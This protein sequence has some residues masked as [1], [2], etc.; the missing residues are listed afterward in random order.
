MFAWTQVRLNLPAWLG[1]GAA[2]EEGLSDDAAMLSEMDTEWPFFSTTLDLIE[3]VLA[4]ADPE[5]A[6]R[7]DDALVSE[8]L[9]PIGEELRTRLVRTRQAVLALRSRGV[10]LA[11]HP[12]LARSIAVRNPYVDP[13]NLMQAS[14]LARVRA[15]EDPR[16]VRALMITINGIAAGMRNT[17]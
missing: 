5:V 13:L 10:L 1:V 2:L 8:E 4:K 7:Y 14:L 9:R 15:S 6:A 17:G 16:L 3:M 11:E 12:V